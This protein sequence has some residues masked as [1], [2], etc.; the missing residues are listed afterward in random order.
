M[1]F[2]TKI[3]NMNKSAMRTFIITVFATNV[4]RYYLLNVATKRSRNTKPKKNPFFY[5][6]TVALHGVFF[7]R[8]L[9]MRTLSSNPGKFK[10]MASLKTM[11]LFCKVCNLKRLY[12]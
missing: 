4:L 7:I 12:I 11:F 2:A 9:V 5:K 10:N 3:S 8:A 1:S 6:S